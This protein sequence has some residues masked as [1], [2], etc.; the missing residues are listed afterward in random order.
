MLSSVSYALTGL[1]EVEEERK[2][3]EIEFFVED[4]VLI[5]FDK[6]DPRQL[7]IVNIESIPALDITFSRPYNKDKDL[8]KETKD[9]KAAKADSSIKID[10][11]DISKYI[12]QAKKLFNSGDKVAAWDLIDRL[13]EVAKDDYRIKTMKGSLLYQSGDFAGAITYWQ[14]S[15]KLNK[16]QADVMMMLEKAQRRK[17]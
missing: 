3:E 9:D 15:L 7:R 1:G 5:I 4:N 14:E 6:L 17:R 16:N 8:A 2:H 10:P 13:E 12:Y 11:K